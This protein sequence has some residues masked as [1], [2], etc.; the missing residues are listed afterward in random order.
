MGMF[1]SKVHGRDTGVVVKSC[2]IIKFSVFV[3][4]VRVFDKLR[5]P[6]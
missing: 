5:L 3:M 6:P 4:G 2:C 1:K